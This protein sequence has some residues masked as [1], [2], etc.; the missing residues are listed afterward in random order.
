MRKLIFFIFSLSL[1][2]FINHSSF[3]Q[4][5]TV[6]DEQ[7]SQQAE[8]QAKP[9][10]AKTVTAIEVKGNK[11]ISSNTVI[12]KMKT[13][14]GSPY[15]ETVIS[16]DLK[17]LYLLGFFSDIKID[18][19]NYKDGLRVIVTVKER[20]IISKITFVGILHITLKDEKIKEALK[21]RETQYL[22]YPNLA[23][24]VHIL[25]KMYEK[26]GFSQAQIDY[27]V[28]VD[29]DTNR[30][31][32]QFTIVENKRVTIKNIIIE[33]N[34]VFKADKILR[35]MKTK[36]GWLFNAGTF[37]DEVLK[38]D[39]ERVKSFY[40]KEGFSDCQVA[41]SVESDKKRPFWLYVT[42][43]INEGKRYLVGNVTI[44]G[45][46]DISQ[47]KII[48]RL[49][50]CLPGK[51]FSQDA[52]KKDVTNV[53]ALYFDSGFISVGVQ[54]VTSLSP[55]TGRIDI[56][57]NITEN[58]IAYVEKIKVRGNVK[59]KDIVVR[60]ELRI[61]PGDKFD[62]D[63]L[64]RS[65]ERLQNLGFFED[66]SYD[67][68]DTSVPNKKDL[69]VDVKESKTGSFS[70][71]GGY[72]TVDQ[73]VGFVE[74]EQKNFD[75][76]NWPY[77]TG[78]GENLKF[79]ASFG[80]VS[81][82][83]DLSF[84]EPWLFDYPVSF[85]FDAYNNTHKRDSDVGYGYDEDIL[86]GDL[87]LGKEI[88]EYVNASL[89]YR[90]DQ[91]KIGSVSD[92]ASNDLLK[93]VGTNIISSTSLAV[94]YDARDNIFDPTKGNLLYNSLQVAG[95]PF[96]GDKNFLKYYG[97][98]S[99]YIPL[100]RGSVLEFRGR[101]GATNPYGNSNEIPIYERF[102][103]GGAD[104]IRGY[105]ERKIGPIDPNT[106]D[107]LGGDALLIGNIEYLYPLFGFLKVAAFYDVGNVWDKID[108]MGSGGFKSGIGL[109]VRV[110]TPIGPI[111]LDYGFPMNK[112]P[113]EDKKSGGRLHFNVSKGF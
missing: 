113:G 14:I 1:I 39:I 5:N 64:K 91:I 90:R 50:D 112:E 42:M 72:S 86:G 17:R 88:S 96:G 7:P 52:L 111:M 98:A 59:T 84:N 48:S 10:K 75:W 62:G 94:S 38:E 18:S 107:P 35:L 27:F 81:N 77:F 89:T 51:V 3:A 13:K 30:A 85:G 6:K 108:K 78:A 49:K 20:P 43:K 23:S 34:I 29:K 105:Q 11:A 16:D 40:N 22:D 82:G 65:K 83:F 37:K 110:K 104:T 15:Q 58:D 26:M 100:L 57:Y 102:F 36:R 80:S 8:E 53:Q 79:R 76:T 9:E 92:N 19:E 71:G 41:Y 12:S 103:A 63:K 67:T 4:E 74:V 68:E 47:K 25:K 60:R 46:K 33:G 28:S 73:F 44:E 95:G 69:V 32:V 106:S 24:D 21:S 99:H 56:V 66:V 31:T 55:G 2:I 87:H 101:I 109:G 54:E 97:R 93:E 45:N 61:K 70:F